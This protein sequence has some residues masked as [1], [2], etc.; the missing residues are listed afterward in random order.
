MKVSLAGQ[1]LYVF[2]FS[3]VADRDW[4]LENGPWHIQ[5]KPLV[6]RKWEPNMRKLDFELSKMPIWFQLYNVP[7]ELFNQKCLSYIS[8]A[9]GTPLYMDSVTSNRERVEFAKVCIEVDVAF[10]IPNKID[11]LV[12]DGST[13]SFRVFAPWLPACCSKCRTYGHFKKACA[14]EAPGTKVWK[15]KEV[16]EVVQCS[17]VSGEPSLHG[18]VNSTT[19]ISDGPVAPIQD[20]SVDVSVDNLPSSQD[21]PKTNTLVDS[22]SFP[23]LQDSIKKTGRD[24][25]DTGKDIV[26][27]TNKFVV[28]SDGDVPILEGR[29]PRAA[30]QETR[31]RQHNMHEIMSFYSAD[32]NY[33]CNADL[34]INGRILIMWKKELSFQVL[35]VNDQSVTITGSF[36]GTPMAITTI[37]GSND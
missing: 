11:V 28:L 15:K 37:Y 34:S 35:H 23:S 32:W 27:S 20:F 21:I 18:A 22:T 30:S 17:T 5:N 29:K 12:K 6:L 7:L 8:S 1:N 31:I 25:L 2:S 33:L 9:L 24:R 16:L 26:G 13:V 36:Y 4:V 19:L 3:S 10:C 14:V